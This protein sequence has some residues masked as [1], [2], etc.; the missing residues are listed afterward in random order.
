MEQANERKTKADRHE[1]L[2]GYF[3]KGRSSTSEGA[4]G[5]FATGNINWWQKPIVYGQGQGQ[6]QDQ[7]T[8]CA[9]GGGRSRGERTA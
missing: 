3:R 6:G 2:I 4:Q 5:Y 8:S 9:M 7:W 1:T